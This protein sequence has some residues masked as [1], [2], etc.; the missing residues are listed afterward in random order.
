MKPVI[1]V[2]N[3]A[4]EPLGYDLAKMVAAGQRY[5]DECLN[6]YW[7]VSCTLVIQDAVPP[8]G[9][10][11]V[12][13]DDADVNGAEGYH[14]FQPGQP[15]RAKV[16][17]KTTKAAGDDVAVTFSHE[18]AELLIDPSASMLVMDQSTGTVYAY[19]I[20]DACEERSFPIDGIPMSDFVTRAWFGFDPSSRK[21][22]YL[23]VLQAPFSLDA[24][25]YAAVLR[26]GEITEIFGSPAKAERFAREDRRG[27]RT[28]LWKRRVATL[29]KAACEEPVKPP[30]IPEAP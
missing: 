5:V 25:G 6:P 13:L 19:E 10:G 11:I 7:G 23:G 3:S 29:L 9:W 12:F 17:V 2:V 8:R 18:L 22:D 14:D 15:P 1:S 20:A 27:H 16:F 30:L 21:Y 4:T 28:D 26:G 24:G